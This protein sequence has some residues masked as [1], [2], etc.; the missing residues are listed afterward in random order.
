MFKQLKKLFTPRPPADHDEMLVNAYCTLATVPEPPFVHHLHGRRD[1]TDPEMRQ[2]LDGFVRYVQ[3]LGGGKMT[4]TRYQVMRHAQRTR[5]QF[6]F[7]VSPRDAGGLAEWALQA[8]ALLVL[9]DGQVRDPQRKVL[10]SSAD[11][12]AE[13]DAVVPFPAAALQRKAATEALLAARGLQASSHLPPVV[14]ESELRLRPAAEARQRAVALLAVALRAESLAAGKPLPVAELEQKLPGLRR[15]LSPQETAFLQE[16][17]PTPA[18]L[19]RF[20]WRYESLLTLE[21]ALGL[22]ELPWPDGPCDATTTSRTLL[23]RAEEVVGTKVRLRAGTEILDALDLHY[24]LQWLVRQSRL[25]GKPLPAGLDAGVISE[26]HHALNW[27]SCFEDS[28]WDDTD[29]PT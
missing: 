14:A 15:V 4:S 27:L 24:R 25:D 20:S 9:P 29:T 13:A 1:S 8:N 19:T 5:H 16:E 10:V 22:A 11:G 2:E 26:R 6:A 7:S 21:W 17:Q 12:S 23:E 3:S 18:D 28:D